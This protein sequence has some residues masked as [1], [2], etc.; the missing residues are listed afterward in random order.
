MLGWIP[1]PP[2]SITQETGF[3]VEPFFSEPF[4]R[5]RSWPHP[6]PILIYVSVSP[7]G[8][9]LSPEAGADSLRMHP[10]H[11]RLQRTQLEKTAKGMMSDPNFLRSLME[12]DFDSITQSQLRTSEVSR[13]GWK[14]QPG[15]LHEAEGGGWMG[16]G[17]RCPMNVRFSNSSS[18]P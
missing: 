5:A 11:E 12:I 2:R 4:L 6:A 7:A 14:G 3:C 8:P 15:W 18:S 9:L 10:H 16:S 17:S 13:D 1:L